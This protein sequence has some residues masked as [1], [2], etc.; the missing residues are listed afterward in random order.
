MHFTDFISDA[1]FNI[2]YDNSLSDIDNL[3]LAHLESEIQNPLVS[4]HKKNFLEL[5]NNINPIN[6]VQL[7]PDAYANTKDPIYNMITFL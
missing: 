6:P 1:G 2:F 4:V 7:W 3:D 5:K